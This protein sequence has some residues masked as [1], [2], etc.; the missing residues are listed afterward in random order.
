MRKV[1]NHTA[2]AVMLSVLMAIFLPMLA[3]GAADQAGD[4]ARLIQSG[5]ET[6][7][8][9]ASTRVLTTQ[10][11]FVRFVGAPAS[12]YFTTSLASN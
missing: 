12:S 1:T 11:G 9:A 3:V 6:T 2:E 4:I 10:D 8:G 7:E 5:S